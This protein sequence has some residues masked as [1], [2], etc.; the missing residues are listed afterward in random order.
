MIKN[1]CMG[2][3]DFDLLGRVVD[4]AASL[5]LETISVVG[6]GEP[7][8]YRHFL[9]AIRL[10]RNKLPKTEI[11]LTTNGVL[12]TETFSKCIIDCQVDEIII[13]VNA[14]SREKY[15]WMNRVDRFD[16]VVSNTKKFLALLNQNRERKRTRAYVQ[17]L[18]ELHSEEEIE[19]FREFWS[20]YSAPNASVSVK[21]VTD[22]MGSVDFG[23]AGLHSL[24]R[25]N[26]FERERYP[27]TALYYDR[28]VTVG[29]KVLA[30]CMA[31]PT[32][33]EGLIIGDVLKSDLKDVLEGQRLKFLKE[34]NLG[35]GLETIYPCDRC[36][37]WRAMPNI[38]IRNRIQL[39]RR[40][41]F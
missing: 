6:Y 17:I 13:S 15:E 29:G 24:D 7:L 28:V 12:L 38:Y 40:K 9:E 27:C 19:R 37:R 18:K 8:L 33:P 1:R 2:D 4:Q 26:A 35:D 23:W 5:Q 25:S 20:P 31:L 11:L 36:D 22:W 10:I 16:Q 39:T 32:M 21:P 14:A 34:L 41:W 30:C 3:I